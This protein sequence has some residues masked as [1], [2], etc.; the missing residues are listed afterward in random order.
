VT[1]E[2]IIVGAVEKFASRASESAPGRAPFVPVVY[3]D[4]RREVLE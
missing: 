4:G 2:C 3:V 1:P